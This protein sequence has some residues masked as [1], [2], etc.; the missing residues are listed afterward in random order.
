VIAAQFITIYLFFKALKISKCE[1]LGQKLSPENKR[2]IWMTIVLLS[3]NLITSL[4]RVLYCSYFTFKIQESG[5]FS[6]NVFAM[7]MLHIVIPITD[8]LT[9][10]G[11]LSLVYH[12]SRN[13]LRHFLALTDRERTFGTFDIKLLLSEPEQPFVL[14]DDKGRGSIKSQGTIS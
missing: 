7:V 13:N 11:M 2:A 8:M 10:L 5:I 9:A 12:I 1:T 3:I 6:L 14:Q 4:S